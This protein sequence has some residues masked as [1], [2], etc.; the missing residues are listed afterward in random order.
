MGNWMTYRRMKARNNLDGTAPHLNNTLPVRVLDVVRMES[1]Y[2]DPHYPEPPLASRA[3]GSDPSAQCA[4][5]TG[6]PIET[7]RRVLTYVFREQP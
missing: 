3:P 2:L 7:V 6:V 4:A 1:D 5:A